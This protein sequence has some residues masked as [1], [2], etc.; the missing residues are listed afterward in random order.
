MPNHIPFEMFRS[1][2]PEDP[3]FLPDEKL[4]IRFQVLLP[5]NKI[6]TAEIRVPKQSVNRSKH[7]CRPEWVLLSLYPKYKNCGYGYFEVKDIPPFLMSDSELVQFNFRVGHAPLEENYHHS[8]IQAYKGQKFTRPL[9]RI[10]RNRTM[11]MRFR[12][13]IV[14]NIRII[15]RPST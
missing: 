3:S 14:R 13:Q 5:N 11:K 15:Q 9:S 8:E 10:D 2:R 1:G 7:E 4:Y 6:D 12:K